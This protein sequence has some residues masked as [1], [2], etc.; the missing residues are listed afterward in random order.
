MRTLTI[1]RCPPVQ[2]AV[3]SE[4]SCLSVST[5]LLSAV[6]FHSI[7]NFFITPTKPHTLQHNVLLSTKWSAISVRCVIPRSLMCEQVVE[8]YCYCGWNVGTASFKWLYKS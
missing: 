5:I 6:L 3:Y 8:V 1:R 2:P 7:R 4:L